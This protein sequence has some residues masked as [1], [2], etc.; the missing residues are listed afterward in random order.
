[1]VIISQDKK[2]AIN[3]DNIQGIKIINNT[4]LRVLF[5]TGLEDDYADIGAYKTEERAV[6]ILE[7]IS[8]YKAIFEYYRYSP[9]SVQNDI[10][11]DFIKD[12]VM[13]DTYEMPEE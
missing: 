8:Y 5:V 4:V 2:Q 1:M 13:F 9:K 12:D 7:E 3:F 6:Q 10:A 11:E